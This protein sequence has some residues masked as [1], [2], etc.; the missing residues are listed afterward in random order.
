MFRISNHAHIR[1]QQVKIYKKRCFV[2]KFTSFEFLTVFLTA[3]CT[4]SWWLRQLKLNKKYWK[5]TDFSKSQLQEHLMKIVTVSVQFMVFAK[6]WPLF[7]TEITVK[8]TNHAHIRDQQVEIYKNPCFVFDFTSLD[9]LTV[10]PTVNLTGSWWRRK[11]KC[12]PKPSYAFYYS[13]YKFQENRIKTVAV[14]VPSCPHTNIA[15][16]TSSNMLMS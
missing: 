2:F 7:L 4:G 15:A 9:F 3:V 11:L 1:D 10:F 16:V 13:Y 5:P 8:S 14:T 6:F 12:N